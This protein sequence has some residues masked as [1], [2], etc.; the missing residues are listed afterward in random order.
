MLISVARMHLSRIYNKVYRYVLITSV[1]ISFI[2]LLLNFSIAY[3]SN[4]SDLDRNNP[5]AYIK[6]YSSYL[7]HDKNIIIIGSV[8]KS[9]Y[10][11]FPQNVTID[12]DVYNNLTNSNETLIEKPY[13]TILYTN[14]EPFPFKFK[15]S[16]T[17]Y[18]LTSDTEPFI[19][20][21][22]NVSLPFTKVNTFKL[23]YPVIPQAKIKNYM[24]T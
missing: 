24:V 20:K 13:N 23:D 5:R 12:I 17:K 11:I 22:E 6:N 3:S 21:S 16:S 2:M 1:S 15:I 4:Q 18:S 8:A 10:Q 9:D 14:N 7:D 19:Y